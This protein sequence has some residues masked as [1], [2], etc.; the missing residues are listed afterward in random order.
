M[1]V[2][3]TG[4]RTLLAEFLVALVAGEYVRHVTYLQVDSGHYQLLRMFEL[5]NERLSSFHWYM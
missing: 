1:F 2:L 4:E 5:C 3:V